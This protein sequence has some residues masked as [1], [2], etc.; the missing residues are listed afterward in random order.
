MEQLGPHRTDFHEILCGSENKQRL[1][2]CT[3]LA[4]WFL[5]A[6]AKLRKEIISFVMSVCP[7]ARMEQLGPH[8]TDFHEILCLNFF[9]IL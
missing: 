2:S 9:E 4:A 5:G 6:F 7:S 3:T 8:R 1:L